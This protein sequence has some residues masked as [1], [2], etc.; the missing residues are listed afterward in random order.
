MHRLN[1]TDEGYINSIGR[2]KKKCIASQFKRQTINEAFKIIKEFPN[3]WTQYKDQQDT[4]SPIIS[5]TSS[6]QDFIPWITSLGS[7]IKIKDKVK[8][9]VPK[10]KTI[11]KRP[12]TLGGILTRYKDL[13]KGIQLNYDGHSRKCGHCG[14]CGHRGNLKNMVKETNILKRKDGKIIKL[15]QNLNCRDYGV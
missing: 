5:N 4:H 8:K 9:L 7:V 11:Y 1:E 6:K 3:E 13:S 15:K 14:L 12:Q 10:A 2:L